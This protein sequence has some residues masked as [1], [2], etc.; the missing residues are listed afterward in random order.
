[1]KTNNK[2]SC[3]NMFVMENIIT[4]KKINNEKIEPIPIKDDKKL[5]KGFK[6]T[7]DLY[8]NIF[9]VAP[10][11]SGK[12]TMLFKLL[13]DFSSKDTTIICFVSTIHNDPL[14]A[15]IKKYFKKKKINLIAHMSMKNEDGI[16]LLEEIIE[17]LREDAK[18]N[19]SESEEEKQEKQFIK[20]YVRYS[21]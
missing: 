5:P 13:K 20:K 14:W 3:Y 10:T 21:I 15:E 9:L 19:E 8:T 4:I 12:T 7:P 1:M 18:E 2:L 16:N 6:I 11:N 17:Q